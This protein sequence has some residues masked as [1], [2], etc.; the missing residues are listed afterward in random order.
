MCLTNA[1]KQQ[2]I[3]QA[4]VVN[5]YRS[6]VATKYDINLKPL[7][8]FK[9]KLI[10]DS[11]DCYDEFINLIDTISEDHIQSIRESQNLP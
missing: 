4:L 1:D 8:L 7:I 9:S 6:S 11:K 5:S 2:R 3:I 10:S